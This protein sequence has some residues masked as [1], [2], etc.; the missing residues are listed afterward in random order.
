MQDEDESEVVKPDHYVAHVAVPS[1]VDV[2]HMLVQRQRKV[3]SR[4]CV[5]RQG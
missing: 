1:Q 2:E 3:M 5:V 4:M